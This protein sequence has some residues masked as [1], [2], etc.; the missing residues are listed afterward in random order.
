V[1][2]ATVHAL[3][4][5]RAL[6]DSS[7]FRGIGTYLR[8]LLGG[9]AGRPG[10]D[11][12]VLATPAARL[13]PGVR[14]VAVL[15]VLANR[16]FGDVEHRLALP[17]DI[18]RGGRVDVFHGTGQDPPQSCK[19]PWVQTVHSLI[20]LQYPHPEL[21]A[22]RA[23]WAR[24][25]P[26]LREADRVIAVS[27]DTA[28][29]VVRLLRV[30]ADRVVVAHLGVDAAFTPGPPVHGE[31]YVLYVGEY[32]PWKGFAEAFAVADG[33]AAAGLPHR[34]RMAG[35]LAPWT[36]PV[37]RDVLSR[38]RHPERVDLLGYRSREELV[39]LYRG[40]AALVMTSRCEG[41]GL[42][43]VE[44]MACGVPVVGFANSSLVE[45][46]GEG[47]VQVPDGDVNAMTEALVG[48]LRDPAEA[49]TVGR[50]GLAWSARFSWSE[51]AA[52]HARVYREAAS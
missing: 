42:P 6:Y 32:G 4:D 13:P 46:I 16:R 14:R 3:L 43:V 48:L 7:R 9:L 50:R 2:L 44:A 34:L 33:L 35:R 29:A 31:P 28:A 26:R 41:F 39:D 27:A 21:A 12:S 11:V 19:V 17:L 23:R 51:C 25:S 36:E 22:E 40:A 30:P 5:G 47:G 18:R 1:G 24:I 10:L 37:V 52:A 20:P 15:R 49:A 45:V 38:A 8:Q